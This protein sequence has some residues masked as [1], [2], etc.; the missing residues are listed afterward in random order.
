MD[1]NSLM[2][3]HPTRS[4]LV[5]IARLNGSFRRNF[6]RLLGAILYLC[7]LIVARPTRTP[8]RGSTIYL[9]FASAL[10]WV[11]RHG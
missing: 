10:A 3:E 9:L 7:T 6:G 5:Q 2:I 8:S 1:R 4:D 11:L